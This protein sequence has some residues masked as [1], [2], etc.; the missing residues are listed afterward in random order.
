MSLAVPLPI[1]TKQL[2]PKSTPAGAADPP[3]T[4]TEEEA[5]SVPALDSKVCLERGAATRAPIELDEG[6]AAV[7]EEPKCEII[8]LLDQFSAAILKSIGQAEGSAA[9]I[10]P[11]ISPSVLA[12]CRKMK[13]LVMVA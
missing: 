5:E 7:S 2:E 8:K 4:A 3:S 6:A 1:S 13:L 9:A 12:N 10:N 11:G